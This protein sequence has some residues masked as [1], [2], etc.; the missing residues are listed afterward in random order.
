V[1]SGEV[2]IYLRGMRAV[3]PVGTILLLSAALVGCDGLGQGAIELPPPEIF[4]WTGGQPISFSPPPEEW[5]RSRYQN[6]GAEGVDFVL[7]GSKGEMIFVA[8]RFFLGRRDRCARMQNLLRD[9]DEINQSTFL[10][11]LNKARLYASDHFNDHEERTIELTNDALNEARE[12]FLD[13]DIDYAREEL[14]RALDEASTIS[15]SV[16]ET[17]D[18]VIFKAEENS[19]YPSL[20]VG[21]PEDGEVAGEPAIDVKFSFNGHGSKMLGRR[22]YVVE[23]NRMFELGFQGLPENLPLFEAIVDSITFPPG[24]CEH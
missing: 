13:G 2:W 6:G 9:L 14:S 19:V 15:Y 18:E 21:P 1:D 24:S 17:V 10:K 12:A 16:E 11:E 3:H 5:K 20:R 8:E 4:T 22:I 23:N 7:A